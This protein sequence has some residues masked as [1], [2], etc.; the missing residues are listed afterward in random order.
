[1]VP[2]KKSFISYFLLCLTSPLFYQYF[3]GSKKKNFFFNLHLSPYRAFA[4]RVTQ[5]KTDLIL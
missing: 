1:M 4:S 3:L 2:D 5:N